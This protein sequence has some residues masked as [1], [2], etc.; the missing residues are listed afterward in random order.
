MFHERLTLLA[1]ERG[2]SPP[3]F[4]LPPHCERVSNNDYDLSSFIDIV[5][6]SEFFNTT[7]IDFKEHA[8]LR[9]TNNAAASS[10]GSTTDI[11]TALFLSRKS[12]DLS[13]YYFKECKRNYVYL[14]CI[15]FKTLQTFCKLQ[16]KRNRHLSK[17]GKR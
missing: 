5:H 2:K 9:A 7:V 6:L 15:R 11:D 17:V 3:H 12:S 1:R 8:G 4:V 10:D 13:K 14:L 16:K